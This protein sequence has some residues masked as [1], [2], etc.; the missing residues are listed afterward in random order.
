MSKKLMLLAL[1]A[2]TALAMTA[3]PSAASA[4]EFVQTCSGGGTCTG[5]V[6]STGIATLEEDG[7]LSVKCTTT[8]GTVSAPNN[9]STGT[10]ELTFSGCTE[11][12]LGT[13]CE[14]TGQAN[15]VIK[16]NQMV[17]HN[18]Y[19]DPNKTT[20]GVLVT[21]ANVTFRCP[22]VNINK[23]VTGNII[24]HIENPNCG[25]AKAN[26]TVEFAAGASTG[27]QKWTQVTTTGTVFDLITASSTGTNAEANYTTSS[28][29]GTGH[30]NWQGGKTVTF[31]C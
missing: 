30:I 25:I 28:Q 10:L 15:G 8:T 26:H 1:G 6:E 2:L 20:P 24:G 22:I 14:S 18:V 17:T 4:G 9:S 12:T 16:T 27:T 29:V 7:G 3:L 31:D 19:I 11:E 23:T 13:H 21:G 5:T